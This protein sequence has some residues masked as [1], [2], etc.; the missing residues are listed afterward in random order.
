MN[1]RHALGVLLGGA[2]ALAGCAEIE[3]IQLE[4]PRL[5]EP[6]DPAFYASR[7]DGNRMLEPIDVSAYR[8][9]LLRHRIPFETDAAPGT[10]L[11]ETRTHHLY[12]VEPDGWAMRYG[13]S[14]GAEGFGWTG[15]GVI[16][17]T[18][19]WP[20]WTPPPSMIRRKPELAR[21]ADGMPGGLNN[22]LGARALYIYFGEH[23]SGY[24]IHG[25]NEPRSIGRSAS[26]GC[27]RMINQ[28]VIDL[29]ERVQPGARVIVR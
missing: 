2:A 7:A 25:T 20:R 6:T 22:P 29:Y 15:S 8:P 19:R 12:L 27:F 28:D 21:W 5:P 11:I 3:P 24:R 17:R 10:I 23:D 16:A 14:I 13:V 9:D 26:S 1:R 4:G 18:A